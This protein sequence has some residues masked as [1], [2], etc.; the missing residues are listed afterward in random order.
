MAMRHQIIQHKKFCLNKY[1]L[2]ENQVQEEE[3]VKMFIKC[4][5][6]R[7]QI[8]NGVF[9]NVE[10]LSYSSMIL[11]YLYYFL[12]LNC[13]KIFCDYSCYQFLNL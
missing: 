3:N 10:M 1:L 8:K 12:N 13:F 9:V 7:N 5:D 11:F 2:I 4:Y 6:K